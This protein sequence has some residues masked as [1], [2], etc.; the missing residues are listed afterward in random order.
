VDTKSSKC[1]E[2]W[3][4]GN[5]SNGSCFLQLATLSV[6]AGF[7]VVGGRGK[8]VSVGGVADNECQWG[9]GGE[10]VE[11]WGVFGAIEC[12]SDDGGDN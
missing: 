1:R 11:D 4:W 9:V 12:A 3:R 6:E 7:S 8:S 2:Q 10:W 5:A